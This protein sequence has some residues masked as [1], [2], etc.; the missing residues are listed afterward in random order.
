LPGQGAGGKDDA[1]GI[2]AAIVSARSHSRLAGVCKSGVQLMDALYG[3]STPIGISDISLA[4]GS[5]PNSTPLII[6]EG[7]DTTS[8]NANAAKNAM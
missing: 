7:R 3:V 4:P 2:N 5:Y 8:I 6:G 1:V